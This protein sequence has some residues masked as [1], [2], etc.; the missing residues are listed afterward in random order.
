[1]FACAALAMATLVSA[2]ACAA[3]RHVTIVNK[4]GYTM[5]EFYGSN[6]GTTDWQEDVL[7]DYVLAHGESIDVNFDDATGYC[8]FDFLA[9]FEDGDQVKQEDVDVCS[10]GIFT[11]N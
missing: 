11:F 9:I 5:V 6:N 3:N 8:V 10:V 2:P 1:M 4:T 7:G